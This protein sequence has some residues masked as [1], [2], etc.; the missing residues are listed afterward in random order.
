[1]PPVVTAP[2]VLV[3]CRRPA[4]AAASPRD[5]LQGA[6]GGLWVRRPTI[7]AGGVLPMCLVGDA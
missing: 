2:D 6:T 5:G 1:M 3:V 4:L 7:A